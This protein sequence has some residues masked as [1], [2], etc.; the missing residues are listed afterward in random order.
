[1]N[2]RAAGSFQALKEKDRSEATTA[3]LF[4]MFHLLFRGPMVASLSAKSA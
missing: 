2:R 4:E 1:M 3:H